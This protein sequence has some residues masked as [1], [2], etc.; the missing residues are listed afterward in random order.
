MSGDLSVPRLGDNI[1]AAGLPDSERERAAQNCKP[2]EPSL[3]IRRLTSTVNRSL[4]ALR[5][6]FPLNLRLRPKSS[7]PL[8]TP[9]RPSR[10]E[11]IASIESSLAD[12]RKPHTPLPREQAG[13]AGRAGRTRNMQLCLF[14]EPPRSADD[15]NAETT[16]LA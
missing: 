10:R 2:S 12:A 14:K 11:R 15:G 8:V 3:L 16:K 7:S 6:A 5:R 13:A 4:I 9:K 1:F